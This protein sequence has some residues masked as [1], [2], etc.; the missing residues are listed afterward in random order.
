MKIIC[1]SFNNSDIQSNAGILTYLLPFGFLGESV[2]LCSLELTVISLPQPPECRYYHAQLP[3]VTLK[4]YSDLLVVCVIKNKKLGTELHACGP[5]T[6][7]TR[8]EDPKL[9]S[10]ENP[11]RLSQ[12][13]KMKK[14]WECSTVVEHLCSL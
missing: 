12:N 13:K 10:L 2:S 6:W 4:N 9:K 8:Q 1:F 14:A 7:Q 5:A 3:L 11:V